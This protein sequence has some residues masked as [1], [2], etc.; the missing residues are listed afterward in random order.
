MRFCWLP[1]WFSCQG[2]T[3]KRSSLTNLNQHNGLWGYERE[4][5]RSG[6]PIPLARIHNCQELPHETAKSPWFNWQRKER[7]DLAQGEVRPNLMRRLKIRSA[8]S[9]LLFIGIH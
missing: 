8:A 4:Y 6:V 7:A 3:P 1:I 5:L 2:G 9:C